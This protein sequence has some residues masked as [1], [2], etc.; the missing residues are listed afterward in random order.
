MAGETRKGE[1]ADLSP[2]AFRRLF[3]AEVARLDSRERAILARH[4]VSAFR[5]EHEFTGVSGPVRCP[6][7][8]V[9]RSGGAVLGY[10]EVEDEYGNGIL[11]AGGVVSDRGTYGERLRLSLT[12]FERLVSYRRP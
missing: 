7:W 2:E 11:G 6:V 4:Q 12:E 10:D 3:A 5:I 8:V 9:A 1:R